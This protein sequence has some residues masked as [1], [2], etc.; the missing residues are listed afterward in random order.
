VAVRPDGGFLIADAGNN[1]VR[2]VSPSG[3]I[4]TVAGSSAQG[5]GGDGGA[6]TTAQLNGPEGVAATA[7]GGFLIAAA[8]NNRV[9]YVDADLRPGPAGPPGPQGDQGPQGSQG[10]QGVPGATL[11]RL[12]VALSEDKLRA[13]PGA[14]LR[15]RY[16]VT[17]GASVS[18]DL[19]K[20]KKRLAL[21][22]RTVK[23][24]RNT[25][26]LKM[27]KTT[28]RLTL[29]LSASGGGQKATDQANLTLTT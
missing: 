2:R 22:S 10:P 27:P 17:V 29:K 3:R 7:D 14:R 11:N 6:A 28:G 5:S 18:F 9:R 4:T 25:L 21:V 24:G 20:G 16:V 23:A 12:L 15:L 13:R 19:S 26:S 8:G 1:R